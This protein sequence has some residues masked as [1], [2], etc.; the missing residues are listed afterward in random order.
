MDKKAEANMMDEKMKKEEDRRRA[1]EDLLRQHWEE[2]SLGKDLGEL[3][4]TIEDATL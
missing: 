3:S 4:L 1:E 2:K